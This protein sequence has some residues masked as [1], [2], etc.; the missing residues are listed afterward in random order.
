MSYQPISKVNFQGGIDVSAA[1]L[2]PASMAALSP[3]SWNT[4][5]SGNGLVKPWSGG[6]S[7]G[8]GSGSRKMVPFGNTWGGIKSYQ[9]ANK[10]FA[11]PGAVGTNQVTVSST[12]GFVTGITCSVSST[13]TLPTGLSA[14]PTLYYIIV[15]DG[16]TLA[17]A[18]TLNNALLG[19]AVPITAST[20]TGTVT[21][22]V[23]TAAVTASGN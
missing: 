9:Y 7:Q 16:T 4:I 2:S 23:S 18:S 21:I 1:L 6:T 20:G 17:F 10:T 5:I 22:N 13:G 12:A 8:A 14:L 11:A 19:V 15:I 3:A